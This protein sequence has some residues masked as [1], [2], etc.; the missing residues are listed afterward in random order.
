[1]FNIDRYLRE[2]EMDCWI[3]AKNEMM[4]RSAFNN[5]CFFEVGLGW[6]VC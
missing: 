6:S 4:K 3:Q 2:R 1:M 5:D